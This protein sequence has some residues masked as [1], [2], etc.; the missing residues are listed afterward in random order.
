[1]RARPHGLPKPREH[2]V[3]AP[4]GVS[5]GTR[6]RASREK[7]Q[8]AI[9]LRAWQNRLRAMHAPREETSA[10]TAMPGRVQ[11]TT[12]SFVFFIFMRRATS[13]SLT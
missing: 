12:Q 13:A 3:K 1:M 2:R 10:E 6:T 7:K 8:R 4:W 9:L 11:H 5:K